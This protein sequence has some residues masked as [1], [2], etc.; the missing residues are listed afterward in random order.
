MISEGARF[1]LITDASQARKCFEALVKAF[2]DL[3]DEIAPHR[4]SYRPGSITATTYFFR[5]EAIWGMQTDGSQPSEAKNRYC[6][7]FGLGDTPRSAS[8]H[9]SVEVNH[10][11]VGKGSV[12]GRFLTFGDQLFIG[13]TGKIGGGIRGADG[14]AIERL[15][16]RRRINV[17]IDGR[18]QQLALIAPIESSEAF[19][20]T[21]A[22]FVREMEALREQVKAANTK[23]RRT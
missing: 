19:I 21:L 23:G 3:A 17:E 22:T 4:A 13:H 8:H 15:L 12:Q 20:T 18:P 2:T 5:R 10:P 6:N 9:I 1:R 16:G 14:S 11:H 7:L